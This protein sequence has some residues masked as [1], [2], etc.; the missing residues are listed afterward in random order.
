MPSGWNIRGRA[1]VSLELLNDPFEREVPLMPVHLE[2]SGE[3]EGWSYPYLLSAAYESLLSY[4][5]AA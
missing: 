3:L 1:I 5:R 4:K 2:V